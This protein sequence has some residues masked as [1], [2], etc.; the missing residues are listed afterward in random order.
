MQILFIKMQRFIQNKVPNITRF[1]ATMTIL[2]SLFLRILPIAQNH[3]HFCFVAAID[4]E[5]QR[6]HLTTSTIDELYCKF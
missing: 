6:C 2:M 1:V 5:F 3:F 4:H